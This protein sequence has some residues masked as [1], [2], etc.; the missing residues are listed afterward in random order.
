VSGTLDSTVL[1]RARAA[2][3]RSDWHAAYDLFMEADSGGLLG[4]ADL[5]LLADVAYAAGHLDIT[6]ELW[7][8]AHGECVRAGDVMAAAGAAARVAMH[9]LFDTALMAPVRGWLT[10]AERLLEGQGETPVHAWVAV[11]RSYERLLVGDLPRDTLRKHRGAFNASY[12]RCAGQRKRRWQ[13]RP[14]R[15]V[16]RRRWRQR[17]RSGP[18]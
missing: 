9:L 7:E 8:R 15:C 2:V 4:P 16:P 18:I 10:R 11:V 12:P 17:G 14:R 1:E 5:P 3:S 13:Q 6:I